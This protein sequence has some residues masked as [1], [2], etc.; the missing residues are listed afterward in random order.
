MATTSQIIDELASIADVDARLQCL[1]TVVSHALCRLGAMGKLDFPLVRALEIVTASF[2]GYR[3]QMPTAEAAFLHRDAADQL[4]SY[5]GGLVFCQCGLDAGCTSQ[6][7]HFFK[8]IPRSERD[9][10][11]IQLLDAYFEML[12]ASANLAFAKYQI[13]P[14]Y[15]SAQ[16]LKDVDRKS[17]REDREAL[18]KLLSRPFFDP[19]W[20]Q[21]HALINQLRYVRAL[22]QLGSSNKKPGTRS[23]SAMQREM[24]GRHIFLVNVGPNMVGGIAKE[25][26][27]YHLW[28][29]KL[30]TDLARNYA[31]LRKDFDE[32]Q[33]FYERYHRCPEVALSHVIGE[34]EQKEAKVTYCDLT[35]SA[36]PLPWLADPEVRYEMSLTAGSTAPEDQSPVRE[37]AFWGRIHFGGTNPLLFDEERREVIVRETSAVFR[38]PQLAPQSQTRIKAFPMALPYASYELWF[39][40]DICRSRGLSFSACTDEHATRTAFLEANWRDVSALHLTTHGEGFADPPECSN[41]YLAAEG[42]VVSRVSFMDILSV[43]WSSL[44]LV[45]LNACVSSHGET[46]SGEA[47]LSLAWAFRASGARAVIANRWDVPVHVTWLFT[48]AF[49]ETWFTASGDVPIATAFRNAVRILKNCP[50]ACQP[51]EWG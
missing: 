4:I 17:F 29:T 18:A 15:Q 1:Q 8:H 10:D 41:L 40:K 45:L 51:H 35:R 20:P 28:C 32:L 42:G 14:F 16:R 12:Q 24:A 7:C 23:P 48:K 21:V 19:Q 3:E 30:W 37:I 50:D 6:N 38:Y 34:D 33:A 5:L 43:D 49:Y 26:A 27:G 36:L 44:R 47:A 2:A 22:A 13:K 9:P 39:L 31:E 11:S 25:H 46:K